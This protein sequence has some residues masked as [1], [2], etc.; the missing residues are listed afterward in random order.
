MDPFS[1][2]ASMISPIVSS[3]PDWDDL[4]TY[5]LANPLA[6]PFSSNVKTITSTRL[7][8]VSP[9]E[10]LPFSSLEACWP[11]VIK[12]QNEQDFVRLRSLKS[13][14]Q[15]IVYFDSSFFSFVQRYLQDFSS[16]QDVFF[17]FLG[18]EGAISIFFGQTFADLDYVSSHSEYPQE[19]DEKLDLGLRQYWP[20]SGTLTFE[21]K[22]AKKT[23]IVTPYEVR[24]SL[25]N[26]PILASQQYLKDVL[27][28]KINP[29]PSIFFRPDLVFENLHVQK[30]FR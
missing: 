5:F 19:L 15:A 28:T 18:P 21:P 6:Q 10:L 11:L 16:L 1:F 9:K 7:Q 14:R 27:G 2:R 23:M 22:K 29:S 4:Q 3:L 30:Y 20:V 24:Q 25:R 17:L 13:L 8:E 12:V 26:N